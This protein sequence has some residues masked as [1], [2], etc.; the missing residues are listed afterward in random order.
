MA[1]DETTSGLKGL[2]ES[3]EEV[4]TN[5]WN[6]SDTGSIIDVFKGQHVVYPQ[7]GGAKGFSREACWPL[8]Y[9]MKV[10]GEILKLTSHSRKTPFG[11]FV[12]CQFSLRSLFFITCCS[13]ASPIIH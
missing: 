9:G 7:E 5:S 11:S 12:L 10:L 13:S 1:I 4:D 3:R 8:V 6:T 2:T